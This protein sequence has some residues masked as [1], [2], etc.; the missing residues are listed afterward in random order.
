LITW[1]S[2]TRSVKK[3]CASGKAAA[4]Q[5]RTHF[6]SEAG[7]GFFLVDWQ[8]RKLVARG[9]DGTLDDVEAFLRPI[10]RHCPNR[11]NLSDDLRPRHLGGRHAHRERY[12]DDAMLQAAQGVDQ[13]LEEGA[14]SGA[15]DLASDPVSRR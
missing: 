11:R 14:W 5:P 3:R 15:R 7:K 4:S 9:P 8:A 10:R 13:L 2:R 12:G 6:K 1:Q